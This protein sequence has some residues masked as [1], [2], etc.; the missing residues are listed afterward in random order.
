MRLGLELCPGPRWGGLT[1]LP[2]TDSLAE[3]KG[4]LCNGEEKAEWRGWE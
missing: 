4:A 1:M 3:F 2:Q